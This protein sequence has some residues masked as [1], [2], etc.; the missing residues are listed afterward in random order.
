MKKVLF[1]LL[2]EVGLSK[3]Y[4]KTGFYPTNL[5]HSK[6]SISYRNYS[7]VCSKVF[8]NLVSSLTI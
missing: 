1:K 6:L 7:S 2:Y 8:I 5:K 4:F 3:C